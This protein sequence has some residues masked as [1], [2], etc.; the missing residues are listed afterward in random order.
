[1]SSERFENCC[2][3]LAFLFKEVDKTINITIPKESGE[4]RK[5]TIR[6]T[7][8][9][10]DEV[11]YLLNDLD[12]ELQQAP[13]SYRNQMSSKARSLR[14]EYEQYKYKLNDVTTSNSSMAAGREQLFGNSGDTAIERAE[15][16]YRAKL[17]Q[18]NETLNRASE[19]VARSQRVAAETDLGDQRES[20]VRT[21]DTLTGTNQELGKSRRLI[22]TIGRRFLQYTTGSL[23]T[24]CCWDS[25]SYWKWV[26]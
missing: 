13:A 11:K 19:S 23:Q 10:L 6:K 18:G 8:K 22:S 24:N 4:Q 5:N 26:S 25:L 14:R 2:E 12:A 3:D 7:Q 1:M 16:D 17:I 21:R 15:L 20:L 9:K